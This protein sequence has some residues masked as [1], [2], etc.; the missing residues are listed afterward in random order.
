MSYQNYIGN[1]AF[2]LLRPAINFF[3]GAD[4]M[5]ANYFEG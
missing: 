2:P 3:I 1:Y 4:Q 5:M